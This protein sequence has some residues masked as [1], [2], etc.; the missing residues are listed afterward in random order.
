MRVLVIFMIATL[1]A[2][3][4]GLYLMQSRQAP[5]EAPVADD[6]ETPEPEPKAEIFA[7]AASLAAGT[8]IRPEDLRRVA[9]DDGS[10]TPEMIRAD[11]EGEALLHGAVARQPLA[12][13]MPIARSATIQPGERGFLAAVLEP[14]KRA[15]AVPVSETSAVGGHVLPGDRVDLIMTYQV[16]SDDANSERDMRASE[17]LLGKLR[18]LA[19]DRELES[20]AREARVGN[21]ITLEVTS[22]QAEIISLARRIGDLSLVLNSVRHAESGTESDAEVEEIAGVNMLQLARSDTPAR[23][24]TPEAVR[25]NSRTMTIDSDISSLLSLHFGIMEQPE[26]EISAAPEE[27]AQVSRRVRVVR[28]IA[29]SEVDLSAS[30]PAEPLSGDTGETAE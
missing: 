21:T 20:G 3:G 18:V 27:P 8:L 1:V 15:I 4:T 11:D 22:K 25:Q 5:E 30:G 9:Y 17:T 10:V 19:I 12:E 14:G 23:D 13:G 16:S 29:V 28:G 24:P 26:G 6:S 7:P 2:G